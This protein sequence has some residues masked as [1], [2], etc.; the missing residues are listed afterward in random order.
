[1]QGKSLILSVFSIALV[2]TGC[3]NMQNKGD[4]ELIG[5]GAGAVIGGVL[6][7]NVGS[8][9]GKLWATGAGTLIGALV[10]SEI[11]KSLDR[12]DRAA[13]Q[14]ANEKAMDAPVGETITWQN[15]ETGH[16]GSVTPVREG[17]S[18]SGKYCREYRQRIIVDGREQAGYGTACQQP[19]GSWKIVNEG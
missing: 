16:H 2:M 4:K 18:E 15:P 10:G 19:D 3:Q 6:G 14:Q 12:A 9:S 17:Q 5:T 1:M 7:S 8:G 11:G 13:L